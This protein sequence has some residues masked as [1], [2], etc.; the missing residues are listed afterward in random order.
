[1]W[2]TAVSTFC[3]SKAAAPHSYWR[4][5]DKCAYERIKNNSVN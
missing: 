5:V 4:Y 3:V 2:W 1:M